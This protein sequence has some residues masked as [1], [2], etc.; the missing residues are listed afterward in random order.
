MQL[1]K[2]DQS[3]SRKIIC[4]FARIAQTT[5]FLAL[6]LM[7]T[8]SLAQFADVSCDPSYMESLEARATLEAQREITQNQNLILKPDSVLEYTCFDSHLDQVAQSSQDLFSES[9]RWGDPPTAIIDDLVDI[10]QSYRTYDEANFNHGYLGGR[11]DDANVTPP[12][13]VTAGTYN[14][15]VMQ[16]VWQ[17]AKCMDF[18]QNEDTD[19]FFTFDEYEQDAEDKRR[20]PQQCE[21]LFNQYQ[22]M[23]DIATD[24]PEQ[25]PWLEDQ[26]VTYF[27]LFNPEAENSCGDDNSKLKTGLLINATLGENNNDDQDEYICLV[28]G[29]YYDGDNCVRP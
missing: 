17:T 27:E 4:K 18:I 25:T 6:L 15:N 7:P 8:L 3:G 13:T 12:N 23:L 22:E 19:G 5:T 14:C 21:K 11:M 20:L 29:C 28:P 10:A 16:D 9:T 26:L 24:D 1:Y 2:A